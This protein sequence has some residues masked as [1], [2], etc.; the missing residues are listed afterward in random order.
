VLRKWAFPSSVLLVV[1]ILGTTVEAFYAVPLPT[2]PSRP[3]T[4]SIPS[5]TS[6]NVWWFGGTETAETSQDG[7]SCE[8]VAVRIDRP[9][10]N[11]R[12][13]TGSIT[14]PAPLDDV[15]SIL[16]DYNRLAIHVPNLVESRIVSQ[17]S[18]SGGE[19]G[20]G[21]YRCRLYQK[22]AQKI[23][24][25]EFGA[26]VTMAM[27]ERIVN[28]G[29]LQHRV[30][31]FQ[32]IDSFFFSGFDGEW[33]AKEEI[34]ENR[35]LETILT[36]VV[37]VRPKGPVPVAALEWRIREDVPTNLRA[38]KKAALGQGPAGPLASQRS[39]VPMKAMPIS[40]VSSSNI[41]NVVAFKKNLGSRSATN[42]IRRAAVRYQAPS[43]VTNTVSGRATERFNPELTRTSLGGNRQEK[44]KTKSPLPFKVT[45]DA[46]ETMAAYLQE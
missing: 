35:E 44:P 11:S 2:R 26:S 25:F 23:V 12:K 27:T 8:L 6:L 17:Q 9:T 20:D 43:P 34:N 7:D 13:I 30:I 14:V 32:C 41:G 16:T 21:S 39:I 29:A 22:G 10:S 36:Y 1:S 4:A 31:G 45:W 19:P 42:V 3:V 33:S 18:R 46:D 37:D 28:T 24:G 5:P 38:V 15:W 40:S